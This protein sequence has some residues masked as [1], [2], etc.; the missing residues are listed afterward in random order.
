MVTL[1]VRRI[2]YED[3]DFEPAEVLTVKDA[4]S[5]LDLSLEAVISLVSRGRLTELIDP[6]ATHRFKNRRFLVRAE[7]E[8]MAEQRAGGRWWEEAN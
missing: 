5:M 2:V 4:A 1:Q 8:E 3:Q 7:V 6:H